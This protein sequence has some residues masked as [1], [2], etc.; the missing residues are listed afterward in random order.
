MEKYYYNS[1]RVEIQEFGE[2]VVIL[3]MESGNYFGF[4]GIAKDIIIL[5]K[6]PQ[7]I[8]SI[9]SYL[10]GVYEIDKATL[11][12][13]VNHCIKELLGYRLIK[14]ASENIDEI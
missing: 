2:E 8:N 12:S 11:F 5:L 1:K 14:E 6:K 7:T 10:L 3:E 13:D 9:I 4:D